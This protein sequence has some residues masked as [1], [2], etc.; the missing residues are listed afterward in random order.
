MHFPGVFGQGVQVLHILKDGRQHDFE[1]K[2]G[3]SAELF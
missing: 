2:H 3:D 1:L